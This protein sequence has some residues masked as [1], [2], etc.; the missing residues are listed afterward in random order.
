MN[1]PLPCTR[2]SRARENIHGK[3]PR[4]T[5][6]CDRQFRQARA[7][8]KREQPAVEN[9]SLSI[10]AGEFIA[11][12]GPSGCG[13]SSLLNIF[14]GRCAFILGNEANVEARARDVTVV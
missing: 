10:A 6:S 3:T 2:R 13:N 7:A 9:V 11:P 1:A 4:A 5:R 12:L 8:R 14:A